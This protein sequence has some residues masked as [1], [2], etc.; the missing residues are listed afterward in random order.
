[1][2]Q[3]F[4]KRLAAVSR[5]DPDRGEGRLPVLTAHSKCFLGTRLH[6]AMQKRAPWC[7]P[8]SSAPEPPYQPQDRWQFSLSGVSHAE[9]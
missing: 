3:T 8:A 1:M 5:E 7:Q 6:G 4:F 9:S 2:A